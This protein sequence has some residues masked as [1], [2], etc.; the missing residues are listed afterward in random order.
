MTAVWHFV[1][2][3]SVE[4]LDRCPCSC[5]V[6]YDYLSV[7]LTWVTRCENGCWVSRLVPSTERSDEGEDALMLIGLLYGSIHA[8][9]G[10]YTSTRCNRRPLLCLL[11]MV[12]NKKGEIKLVWYLWIYNW[13][14]AVNTVCNIRFAVTKLQI[15]NNW[16]MPLRSQGHSYR[17]LSTCICLPLKRLQKA[18]VQ[19]FCCSNM[20]VT[21]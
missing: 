7:W 20:N 5:E 4:V 8:R 13:L 1:E 14:N 17:Y 2:L 16:C 12:T 11:D 3:L 9:G 19:C 15:C 21:T 6:N 18:E 10:N